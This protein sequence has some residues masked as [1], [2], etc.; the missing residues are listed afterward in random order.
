[1][2]E[3]KSHITLWAGEISWK[4]ETTIGFQIKLIPS[5]FSEAVVSV[6]QSQTFIRQDECSNVVHGTGRSYR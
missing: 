6:T 5:E 3:F 4:N 1:M 2:Q